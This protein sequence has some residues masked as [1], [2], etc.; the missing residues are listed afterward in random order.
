MNSLDLSPL[1]ALLQDFFEKA[2]EYNFS[3]SSTCDMMTKEVHF[4]SFAKAK[5]QLRDIGAKE[6]ATTSQI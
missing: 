1:E 5:L 2:C 3:W 4:E 6:R